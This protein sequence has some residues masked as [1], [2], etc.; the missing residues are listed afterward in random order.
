MRV[1]PNP[2]DPYADPDPYA[3]ELPRIAGYESCTRALYGSELICRSPEGHVIGLNPVTSVERVIARLELDARAG[4]LAAEGLS[5]PAYVTPDGRLAIAVR[6]KSHT[7]CG[8]LP[9]TLVGIVD[10]RPARLDHAP[11]QLELPSPQQ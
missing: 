11:L 4:T 5:A 8:A 2:D 9:C 7:L 1:W 6:V 3:Q 10:D